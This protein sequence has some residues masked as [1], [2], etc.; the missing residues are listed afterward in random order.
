MHVTF[1]VSKRNLFCIQAILTYNL[2]GWHLLFPFS[3]KYSLMQLN[4]IIFQLNFTVCGSLLWV[5]KNV[6]HIFSREIGYFDIEFL[7]IFQ[8]STHVIFLLFYYLF[9][10][11][12]T[13]CKLNEKITCVLYQNV[14]KKFVLSYHC[15]SP[16]VSRFYIQAMAW[17][18][19][20]WLVRMK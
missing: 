3:G 5:S 16:R 15:P 9:V 6:L 1:K 2:K 18:F 11:V 19:V 10:I 7:T 12:L 14:V 20:L 4:G 8:Y 13:Y 17:L